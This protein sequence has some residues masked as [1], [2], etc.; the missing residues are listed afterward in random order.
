MKRSID[1]SRIGA[2]ALVRLCM[3]VSLVTVSGGGVAYAALQSQ[4]AM[5]TGNSVQTATAGLTLSTSG[6]LYS[7]SQVGF[8]FTNL[9]PGG[10]AVPAVGNDIYLK[11]TGG[12]GLALKVSVVSTPTNPDN[13]DFAKVHVVLTPVAGG[14]VQNFTLAALIASASTG[15]MPILTPTSLAANTVAQYKIQMSM[16]SDAFSGTVGLI[17]NIDFSFSG[18]AVSS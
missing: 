13:V 15:G 11:N 5:L 1:T 8:S 2:L 4:S 10:S 14:S 18:V 12:V 16:D 7:A 6:T 17:N 9:V 3:V